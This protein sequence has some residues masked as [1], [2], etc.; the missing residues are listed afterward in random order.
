MKKAL[1]LLSVLALGSTYQSDNELRI[2]PISYNPAEDYLSGDLPQEYFRGLPTNSPKLVY[3][4]D[5][6]YSRPNMVK[7]WHYPRP[8]LP[9]NNPSVTLKPTPV[10]NQPKI[11]GDSRENALFK[12]GEMIQQKPI[13]KSN[14]RPVYSGASNHEQPRPDGHPFYHPPHQVN[15]ERQYR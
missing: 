9:M 10:Q 15:F 6:Q 12:L 11:E 14:M 1:A 8:P 4:D 7:N 13:V 5:E 3:V 2:R